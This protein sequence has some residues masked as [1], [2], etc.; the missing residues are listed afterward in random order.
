MCNYEHTYKSYIIYIDED[1]ELDNKQEGL[2]RML[3]LAIIPGHH[4][5]SIAV[6]KAKCSNVVTDPSSLK[7]QNQQEDQDKHKDQDEHKN[8]HEN[9]NESQ[10]QDRCESRQDESQHQDQNQLEHEQRNQDQTESQFMNEEKNQH[11]NQQQNEL[12]KNCDHEGTNITDTCTEKH[13]QIN[14]DIHT[15]QQHLTLQ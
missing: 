8:Q 11:E 1:M 5:S 10:H 12:G 13:G 14:E 15:P 2:S 7:Y 6:A 3:S 4:I 9:Q